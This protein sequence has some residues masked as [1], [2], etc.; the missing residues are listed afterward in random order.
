MTS[1]QTSVSIERSIVGG[2]RS[3][4]DADVALRDC[5]VDAGV[6]GI[7]Y[8]STDIAPAGG[9]PIVVDECTILGRLHA[10]IL[11]RLSNAI[12]LAEIPAGEEAAWPGPVLADQRQRGCVRFS[13]LPAGS[14]TP[15]RY[16]CL[17]QSELDAA[18]LRPV[19]TSARFGLPG[20][21]QLDRRTPDAVRTGAEDE[22][23]MGVFHHL[24]QPHRE[25]YLRAR[26]DDYLRF[27]LESGL[28]FAT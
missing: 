9:G 23:E 16:R 14:R 27:G 21:G 6:D 19:L 15:R 1:G 12:V 25:A 20:Y 22:G 5:L 11:D 3:H 26:L 8:A 28:F 4:P 2:I 17:P 13:Y 24:Q 7:A 18:E 10:R